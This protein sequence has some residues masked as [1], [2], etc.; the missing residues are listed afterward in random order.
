MVK[1]KIVLFGLVLFTQLNCGVHNIRYPKEYFD[2]YSEI[3]KANKFRNQF[4]IGGVYTTHF[5]S[6]TNVYTVYTFFYRNNLCTSII[7]PLTIDDKRIDNEEKLRNAI[8]NG[9][10][11]NH[12]SY[13]YFETIEGKLKTYITD[14]WIGGPTL[15]RY[16]YPIIESNDHLDGDSSIELTSDSYIKKKY[17]GLMLKN[18][19]PIGIL[20]GKVLKF[21]NVN[22]KPDSSKSDF[23]L[24]YIAYLNSKN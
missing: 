7:I 3:I 20:D 8:A 22:F 19:L 10:L 9:F 23:L 5:N 4:K 11:D 17:L 18:S 2:K 16:T 6:D 1:L 24:N 12:F 15:F 21:K 14:E 13:G